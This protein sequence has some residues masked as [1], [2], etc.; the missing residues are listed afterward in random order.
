MHDPYSPQSTTKQRSLRHP[1]DSVLQ[2]SGAAMLIADGPSTTTD[3]ACSPAQSGSVPSHG[4]GSALPSAPTSCD[5][6]TV[7]LPPAALARAA[8]MLQLSTMTMTASVQYDSCGYASGR[9]CD[10]PRYC[11]IGNDCSDC[12]NCAGV[13]PPP[14]PPPRA[15]IQI[16][17]LA[18]SPN[19]SCNSF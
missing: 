11:A 8:F 18:V 10:E 7:R 9:E 17:D 16:K 5:P 12:G 14:P 1:P 6:P 2:T 19:S 4:N 15:R 13:S 3:P